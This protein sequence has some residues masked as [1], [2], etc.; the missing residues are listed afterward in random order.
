ML[1][2][3]THPQEAARLQAL[4][5]L[6][7]LDTPPDEGLDALGDALRQV[8]SVP[9]V[10]VSLVDARRQWFKCRRGLDVPE[11][12]R[13]VSFCSHAILQAGVFVVDDASAD[14]RFADNPLVT[15]DL[16]LR[17]YAG[18]PIKSADGFPLGTLCLLSDRPRLFT[19]SERTLLEHFGQV[20]ER[21]LSASD[22]VPRRD[23]LARIEEVIG[24]LG[25]G[26]VF[27][28]RDGAILMANPAA[29]TILGLTEGQLQGRDSL[30][31][32][33]QTVHADGTAWPG[34][35]HPAMQVL[36]T[37]QACLGQVMGVRKPGG[38]LSWILVNAMPVLEQGRLAGACASFQDLSPL[39]AAERQAL[40]SER[41]FGSL[42]ASVPGLVFQTH[43]EADGRRPLDYVSAFSDTLLG[44]PP[45]ALRARPDGF[46]GLAHTD[47]APSLRN[48]FDQ[49]QASLSALDWTGRV[50]NQADGDPR[51][52]QVRA[53][54]VRDGDGVTRWHGLML[55]VS[56]RV[57]TEQALQASEAR[58]QAL[59]SALPD[60]MMVVNVS[61]RILDARVPAGF[62]PPASDQ[63]GPVGHNVRDFLPVPVAVRVLGALDEVLATGAP[64][65][66]EIEVPT[67]RGMRD[68][69][70]RL[71]ALNAGEAMFLVRDISERR[72]LERLQAHFVATVSHELR[73][74]LTSIYGALRLVHAGVEGALD[75]QARALV[76]VAQANTERLMRLVNDILDVERAASGK[77][78]LELTP[79]DL[80]P[81]VDEAIAAARPL[82]AALDITYDWQA[83][84]ASCL[85]RVD[86]FRVQQVVTNLLSNAVKYSLAGGRVCVR[87]LPEPEHWRLDVENYGEPIPA[88]FRPRLF[89]RFAMADLSDARRR[90]G[91]GLGLAISRSLVDLMSG[92]LDFV[93]DAQRTCF[94]VRLPRLDAPSD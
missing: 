3:A 42:V 57:H 84:T 61:G 14:E 48:A 34:R 73:T 32:R 68:H 5:G 22:S 47:D 51:W 37:G 41:R 13:E 62:I 33:W 88:A 71:R 91:S 11:T 80:G 87:L 54:P 69:E 83:P 35:E 9:M 70:I 8:F 89:E 76:G 94:F 49:A 64:A 23:V 93:S 52:V 27:H 40:E 12:A 50:F 29:H 90:G 31:P 4:L 18:V 77:L 36:K 53:R 43:D 16:H 19:S 65:Q 7:W 72:E 78:A 66:L 92:S 6:G 55:D 59:M 81:L 45:E 1:I 86:P 30:D 75:G 20:V 79:H 74:P 15:G 82:A 44:L 60:L 17:F 46:E 10:L 24:H 21:L 58:S 63:A 56:E 39:R 28:G 25:E 38:S 2:A 26:V 85:A 67:A